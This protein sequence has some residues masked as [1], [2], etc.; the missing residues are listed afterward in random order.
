MEDEGEQQP[1]GG[2]TGACR[3]RGRRGGRGGEEGLERRVGEGGLP[4][5]GCR[6]SRAGTANSMPATRAGAACSMSPLRVARGGKRGSRPER[7][8]YRLRRG[9]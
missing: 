4:W 7:S 2:G 5:R 3:E 1:E 9:W 6:S 8:S